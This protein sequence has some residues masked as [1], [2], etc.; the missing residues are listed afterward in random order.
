MIGDPVADT[1][2]VLHAGQGGL[3]D[4]A[5]DPDYEQNGWVYLSYSHELEGVREGERRERAMTR[6]VRGRIVDHAWIDQEVIFEAP[7]ETYMTTRHHYGC[8]I[9][10]DPDGYLFFAIGDR[11]RQNQAQDL[12]RPNGKI[13]RIHRDG[14]IPED[15][16]FLDVEGAL[17][18]I[19]SYGHRNPQ[20]LAIHPETGRLW[21]TEHGPMGG[22]EL[23]LVAPG[24]NY[25]WPKI[26]YGLN[27][28]GTIVT[29][30]EALRG[31]EQP[32]W[33]W[34]P[35]TAVCGLDFVR[36]DLFPKWRNH[37]LVGALK[38]EEVQLL[39]IHEDRVLHVET[40]LKNAGRVRDVQTGPDG[41]VY[42]VLNSPGTVLRLSPGEGQALLG[43]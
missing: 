33:I 19:Y 12:T 5:I 30:H 6:L 37:L 38:Y 28:N 2:E 17:P 13:H 10:F 1:P 32:N 16:P 9:V 27:Y 40:V 35:S 29:E 3:M 26:T 31:L 20:G 4:V 14:R 41:A 8:R 23:N 36:G 15:N 22:D 34:K 39:T 24:L 18:S 11:G 21:I 25:G 42:I 7:H 43:E